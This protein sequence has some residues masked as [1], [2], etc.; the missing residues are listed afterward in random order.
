MLELTL[1]DVKEHGEVI[2]I[3]TTATKTKNVRSFTVENEHAA[4]VR[5]YMNM[6]PADTKTNRFFLRYRKME[7]CSTNPIGEAFFKKISKHIA[8]FLDLPDEEKYFFSSIRQS[9]T[10]LWGEGVNDVNPQNASDVSNTSNIVDS[11]SKKTKKRE[12]RATIAATEENDDNDSIAKRRSKRVTRSTIVKDEILD[13]V[14]DIGVDLDTNLVADVESATDRYIND[15]MDDSNVDI[16]DVALF[17][18]QIELL[19]ITKTEPESLDFD[20]FSN[21]FE[22]NTVFIK[23]EIIENEETDDQP[24]FEFVGQSNFYLD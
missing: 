10:N 5:K 3:K 15:T 7:K 16:K 12:I 14:D 20:V 6:R 13:D 2:V 19:P 11:T 24:P 21:H 1:N 17:P 8:N 4:L 23:K 22:Q 9:S 18:S